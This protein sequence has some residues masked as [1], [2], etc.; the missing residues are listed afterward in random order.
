VLV[1]AARLIAHNPPTFAYGVAVGDHDGDGRHAL[2]VTGFGVPNTVLRWDGE[3][4]VDTAPDLLADPGRK[5]IGVAC[6]DV[7]GDGREEIYVQNSDTF[8]G[9]KRVGDRLFARADGDPRRWIDLFSLP[10]NAEWPNLIAGRSVAALDRTGSGRYGFLV[11]NYGGP[12][13][14]FEWR[15]DRTLRDVADEAG[16]ALLAG[17]R[18]LLALPLLP[19]SLAAGRMDVFAGNENSPNFLFENRGDGT[20]EEVAARFGVTDPDEHVRGVVA[21][22]ANDDGLFDL[23]YGN[24]EGPHRFF[25]QSSLGLFGDVATPAWT[26][27]S[28]VRS[29]VVADFDNDGFE[30]LFVNNIGEPNRL[31]RRVGTSWI[32]ADPGDALEPLGFGTGAAVADVDGDGRLELVVAHGEAGAQPLGVF[33][34]EPNDNHWVRIAPRPAAGAPARGAIV[35]VAAGGR[36]HLR[37]IDAGSGYLCQMEP[38]AHVGLGAAS[39]VEQVEV[40]WP[41]GRRVTLEDVAVDS[42]VVVPIPAGEP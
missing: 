1:D 18:A 8:A 24:W 5:A 41:G 6:A 39:S 35:R 10:Q 27:P 36:V 30:E 20:F 33:K 2:I 4:L 37:T 3:A 29:I 26:A 25:L 21:L 32:P 19:E 12:L 9:A 22:D 23:V 17:G 13:A 15:D 11:A 14:L 7:D 42:T 40:V 34:A 28:R 16:L 31:F 38:V